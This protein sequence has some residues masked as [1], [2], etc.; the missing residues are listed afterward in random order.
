MRRC[1]HDA[2]RSIS[3]EEFAEALNVDYNSL[4]AEREEALA[5]YKAERDAKIEAYKKDQEAKRLEWEAKLEQEKLE[6][7][8][9]LEEIRA[10]EEAAR[11]EREK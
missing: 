2:D 6:R 10:S 11:L 8:K 3:L 1:D 7:E 4:T 5:A 9:R